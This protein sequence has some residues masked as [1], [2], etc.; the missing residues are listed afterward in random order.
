MIHVRTYARPGNDTT[1]TEY[2]GKTVHIEE[3]LYAN[4]THEVQISGTWN[5]TIHQNTEE[6]LGVGN[7]FIQMRPTFKALDTNF[8]IGNFEVSVEGTINLTSGLNITLS[9]SASVQSLI[10]VISSKS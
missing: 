7:E 9:S 2:C 4:A 5:A 6:E 3:T 8:R 10:Y 1:H